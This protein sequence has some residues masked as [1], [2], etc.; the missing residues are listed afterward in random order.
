VGYALSSGA[1]LGLLPVVAAGV[2]VAVVVREVATRD[3]D[4]NAMAVPG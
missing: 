3:V 1:E 2:V 4:P